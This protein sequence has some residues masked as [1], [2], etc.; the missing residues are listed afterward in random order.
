MEVTIDGQQFIKTISCGDGNC[1]LYTLLEFMQ[2]QQIDPFLKKV[3]L[4]QQTS[5]QVYREFLV[6]D[7][8]KFNEIGLQRLKKDKW[9]TLKRELENDVITRNLLKD[10][11]WF[12]ASFL[13]LIVTIYNKIDEVYLV[14]KNNQRQNVSWSRFAVVDKVAKRIMVRS[15]FNVTTETL[16]ILFTKTFYNRKEYTAHYDLLTATTNVV[17]VTTE[18]PEQKMKRKYGIWFEHESLTFELNACYDE[19]KNLEELEKLDNNIYDIDKKEIQNK[20][21]KVNKRIDQI[22]RELRMKQQKL[23]DEKTVDLTSEDESQGTNSQTNSQTTESDGTSSDNAIT[24]EDAS[25]DE[26]KE[27]LIQNRSLMSLSRMRL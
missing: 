6:T 18:T 12:P 10:R 1:F 27:D 21:N 19:L 15:D 22:Q 11:I 24:I 5:V 2:Q 23:D 9:E 20:I 7:L 16:I 4:E 13:K 8:D 3:P 17:K 25:D 26:R 14:E